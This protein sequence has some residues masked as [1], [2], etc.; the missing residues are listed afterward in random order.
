[1]VD[2]SGT[3]PAGGDKDTSGLKRALAR[4]THEE[5]KTAGGGPR[6]P[7][8]GPSTRRYAS[9]RTWA[10]TRNSCY[11]GCPE[12]QTVP[13]AQHAR[14]FQLIAGGKQPTLQNSNLALVSPEPPEAPRVTHVRRP[15]RAYIGWMAPQHARSV[16]QSGATES[17]SAASAMAVVE[18]ARRAVSGRPSGVSQDGLIIPAPDELASHVRALEASPAALPYHREGWKVALV[19]LTRVCGCQPVVISDQALARVASI[20]SADVKS[21]AAVTLPLT[22]GEAVPVRFDPLQRAWTVVSGNHNLR[23]TGHA[24]PQP[25]S[26]SGEL[27]MPPEG[28]LLGFGVVS[29]PSF[30]QVGR[31]HGRYFLRDGYHRAIGL[32][33]RGITVAPAFVRDI[34]AFEELFPDPRRLLPQE[35]Y[36]GDRPPVLPDLLDDVVSAAV[37]VPAAQKMIVISG[38]EFLMAS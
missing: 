31:F 36:L 23:I 22:Q 29:P 8:P 10:S 37:Q 3:E 32:L 5:V 34:T 33:S 11:G 26:P 17:L 35:S 38:M 28:T 19:D 16:L 25:I 30:M 2:A 18:R 21:V 1:M 24:G 9:A 15:G 20:D 14:R 13:A 6:I 27:L 4:V 7:R 12:S